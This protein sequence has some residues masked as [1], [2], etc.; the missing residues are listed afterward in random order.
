MQQVKLFLLKVNSLFLSGETVLQ[1]L[2]MCHTKDSW[3]FQF[4]KFFHYLQLG[5]LA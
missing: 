2:G 1:E 5:F 4:Y 3:Y